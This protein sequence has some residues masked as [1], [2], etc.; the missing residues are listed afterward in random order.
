MQYQ[1]IS[2]RMM[3][4][5]KNT[6]YFYLALPA[7]STNGTKIALS[8]AVSSTASIKDSSGTTSLS[9]SIST[10]K[11]KISKEAIS[12]STN[13]SFISAETGGCFS[14]S[15]PLDTS[16]NSGNDLTSNLPNPSLTSNQPLNLPR[17]QISATAVDQQFHQDAYRRRSSNH[18]NSSSEMPKLS[19]IGHLGHPARLGG[20]PGAR[21]TGPMHWHGFSGSRMWH[22]ASSGT[23][24]KID[25]KMSAAQDA[26]TMLPT[27]ADSKLPENH[28][29]DIKTQPL[30]DGN[31]E[32]INPFIP[33]AGDDEY[34]ILAV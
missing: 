12:Q 7:D 8:S 17:P 18:S 11:D 15:K 1:S 33:S 4:H 16:A 19:M 22:D 25:I 23:P 34:P 24:T 32:P 20:P 14:V 10:P 2:N 28:N 3:C 30:V 13:I 9:K 21:T 5:W 26:K 27:I 6:F 31:S 29:Q